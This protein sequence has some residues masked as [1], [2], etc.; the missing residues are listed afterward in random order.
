MVFIGFGIVVPALGQGGGLYELFKS[1]PIL[2]A[3]IL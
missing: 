3:M 1:L 2:F